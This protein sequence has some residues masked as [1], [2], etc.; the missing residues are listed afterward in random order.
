MFHK[1]LGATALMVA[2]SCAQA[3]NPL[4]T[5]LFTADPFALV[6]NGRVYLYV[7]KDDAPEGACTPAAT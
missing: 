4:F 2:A 6:D 1:T 7:G 5:N 3:A